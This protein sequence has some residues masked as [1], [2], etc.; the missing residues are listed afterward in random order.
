MGIMDNIKSVFGF[1][2][3]TSDQINVATPSVATTSGSEK[4]LGTAREK[5]GYTMAGGKR[6]TRRRKSHKKTHRR[7]H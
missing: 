2:T 3:K 7:K 1:G 4:M 5:K 6:L